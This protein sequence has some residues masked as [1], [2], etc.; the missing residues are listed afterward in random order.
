MHPVP[1]TIGPPMTDVWLDDKPKTLLT[2][3]MPPPTYLPRLFRPVD[4]R[5]SI[6][7]PFDVTHVLHVDVG[8]VFPRPTTAT[9]SMIIPPHWRPAGRRSAASSTASTVSNSSLSTVGSDE[10]VPPPRPLRP[11]EPLYEQLYD[12]DYDFLEENID[13]YYRQSYVIV[14]PPANGFPPVVVPAAMWAASETASLASASTASLSRPVSGRFR[15][16]FRPLDRAP[17]I[18]DLR[19]PSRPVSAVWPP[20]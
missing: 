12:E 17:T 15:D 13:A 10:R 1:S 4:R 6:S 16:M 18:P 5:A 9:S 20:L 2:S 8:D 14:S 3:D 7:E 19:L 11:A